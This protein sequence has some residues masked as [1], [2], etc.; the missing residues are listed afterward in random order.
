MSNQPNKPDTI[1]TLDEYTTSLR[2]G[3][4]VKVPHLYERTGT[5]IWEVIDGSQTGS[6]GL[7]DGRRRLIVH[8]LNPAVA[9]NWS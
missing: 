1:P 7:T 4:Q 5:L 8:G 2:A 3:D 9:Y 6:V